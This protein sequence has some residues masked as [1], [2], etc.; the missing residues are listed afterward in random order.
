[1]ENTILLRVVAANIDTNNNNN[2]NNIYYFFCVQKLQKVT[3]MNESSYSDSDN[4]LI[5]NDIHPRG[6]PSQIHYEKSETNIMKIGT[7]NFDWS[8]KSIAFCDLKMC[9]KGRSC[10]KIRLFNKLYTTKILF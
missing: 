1:M 4:F 3:W 6:Q 9:K 5:V 10:R 7:L 2:N 8:K